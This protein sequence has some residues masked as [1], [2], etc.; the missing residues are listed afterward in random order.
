MTLNFL[1]GFQGSGSGLL[2]PDQG[3]ITR[4]DIILRIPFTFKDPV[5]NSRGHL[6]TL[7]K[8]CPLSIDVFGCIN[9]ISPAVKNP[10]N[11]NRY[12]PVQ[13]YR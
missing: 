13:Q 3:D 5:I 8:S 7:P 6:G 2:L 12:L 1:Q 11:F 9:Y 4:P 10:E